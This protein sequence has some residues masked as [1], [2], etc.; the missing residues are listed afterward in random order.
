MTCV[1]ENGADDAAYDQCA[2][3]VFTVHA[4][5]VSVMVIRRWR[6]GRLLC[7]NGTAVTGTTVRWPASTHHWLILALRAAPHGRTIVDGTA[8]VIH[9]LAFVHNRALVHR[10][11]FV[12]HRLAFVHD[13][14]LVAGA[15]PMD[16]RTL[17]PGVP[18]HRAALLSG[19][20]LLH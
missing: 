1:G 10:A 12:I 4:A 14:T 19:N 16:G 17:V 11:A 8:F 3:P 2:Q 9:G 18:L 5:M 20:A 13:R 6:R 15:I 7:Y